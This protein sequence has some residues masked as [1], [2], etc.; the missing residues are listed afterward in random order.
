[1]A[2]HNRVT[3]FLLTGTL[4]LISV[5]CSRVNSLWGSDEPQEPVA[6]SSSPAEPTDDFEPVATPTTQ[7][8]LDPK[9]AYEQALDAAY[10]AATISQSAQSADDWK[11]VISRWQEA[12]KLLKQVPSSSSF[13]AIAQTKL[14]QY[15]GNLRIAQQQA[16][17]PRPSAPAGRAIATAPGSVF[18]PVNRSA[19]ESP[20]PQAS[21]TE[22]KSESDTGTESKTDTGSPAVFKVPIKRRASGTPIIDVT[23][24]GGQT[25]EMVVDTGASGT[26]ITQAMAKRLNVVPQGE[27][28]A[29]TASSKGIKLRTGKVQSIAVQGLVA[30]DVQVAIAGPQLDLGLLGQ[31][32]FGSYDV[33]IR[34][35]DIEFQPRQ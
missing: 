7:P 23:F 24:N 12:I 6:V 35:N 15:Q 25:F 5:A 8:P 34:Q 22:S 16:A 14:A 4:A 18:R 17:R 19:A 32:F 9:K 20:S 2:S 11:L 28:T 10:S 33:L 26:V 3:I 1:M 31:D 29:D 27:V 21:D 30:K 13:H